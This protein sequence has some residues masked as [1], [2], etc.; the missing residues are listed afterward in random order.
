[1]RQGALHLVSAGH[2]DEVV[3]GWA[4]DAVVAVKQG[5][6]AQ[7][8]PRGGSMRGLIEDNE[9]VSIRPVDA[10]AVQAGD[11]VLVRWRGGFLL[12]LVRE[13]QPERVLIGNNLGRVN[14][15]APRSD[16]LGLVVGKRA[17]LGKLSKA[18]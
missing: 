5:R 18:S 13:A 15:W 17:D 11:V 12:H 14:G 10:A 3:M 8:R 2:N 7:V 16:V 4:T 9:L 6:T 1:M